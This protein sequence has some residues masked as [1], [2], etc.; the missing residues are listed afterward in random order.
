MTAP[1]PLRL[2]LDPRSIALIGASENPN[3]IGGRPLLY[4]QRF[5]YRG[6]IYPINPNRPEVQGV[7]SYP[8]LAS[9]PEAPDLAIVMVAGDGA[10]K[11]VED[12]AR[13][14]VKVAICMA[15]GFAETGTQGAAVEK[16]M[17]ATARRHGMRLVGPNSQGLVNFGSGVVA[18]FSTMFLEAPPADG[19][20]AIISQSGA[21]SAVPYGLLRARG[22]GVRHCHATGNDSDVT[23]AELARAVIEDDGVK[24]LL[25]YLEA[26]PNAAMLAAVAERARE[27]DV[28]IVALKTGRTAQGQRAAKSHTGALANEDR[29]VDAFLRQQGIWR[30]RDMAGLVSAAEMYLKGWRPTG[31]RLVA[32]SN[33]GASCVMAADLAAELGLPLASFAAETQRRLAAVL[34]GFATTSNPV[35]ITAALL[36]NSRLFS[37]ILP[38]IAQ[39]P[40]ADLFL[41][42]IPVAGQG[43]DVDAFARDTAAFAAA[44]GKPVAVA[45]PQALVADRF[46]AQGIPTFAGETEAVMALDQLARHV[47]L[48]RR[49][50]PPPLVHR[51]VAVPP[52][53]ERFLNEAESLALLAA[54]GLPVVPHRL[55]RSESEARIAFRDLGSPVAVKACSADVPHKSDYGLVALNIVS[56]EAV[57][58]AFTTQM[59]TLQ[60]IGAAPDGIIVAAM[61]EGRREFVLGARIDP[62]FGPVVMVGDGGKYVEALPD[63][64]VLLPPFSPAE[65]RA[66]LE[67]LR[68]APILKGVR[69][70]PPLDIEALAAAAV[71]LGALIAAAGNKIASIDLNPVMVG[72][73]GQGI[74][75]LDALVERAQNCRAD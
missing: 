55:C 8:D 64:A 28:P 75:I 5:G 1:D 66:A 9:L 39:D 18:S 20:V 46:R 13:R 37:D 74:T 47:A 26:I 52:G 10:V 30:A 17:V 15:S 65:A 34:P 33:S 16:A 63:V 36:S 59:A 25:L 68:I 50:P 49:P 2:A 62:V 42:A 57:G 58:Q 51:A 38:I 41:I 69:G 29:V 14:G 32:I 61:A 67:G 22:I 71:R 54:H 35:D 7:K 3:K 40:A 70:E 48:M 4:L 72:P 43:Y 19:P 11:A 21:M 24:L 6:R 27:R 44:T 60:Q 73:A 56:E 45:A 12:C 31:R 53:P 23:V